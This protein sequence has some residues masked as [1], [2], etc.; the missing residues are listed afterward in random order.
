MTNK[1]S[2]LIRL[3]GKTTSYT[4][5]LFVV[6][7]MTRQYNHIHFITID[8]EHYV[9][10][11]SFISEAISFINDAF[12]DGCVSTREYCVKIKD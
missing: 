8:N 7:K 5:E 4:S 10:F 11:F 9:I 12:R 6:T 2:G 3:L 1:N